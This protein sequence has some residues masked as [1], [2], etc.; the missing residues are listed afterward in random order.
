MPWRSAQTVL[1]VGKWGA[2]GAVRLWAVNT[3]QGLNVFEGHSNF[4]WSVAFS[5]DGQ[6]LA[7]GSADHSIR[8]WDVSNRQCFQTLQGHTNWVFVLGFSPDG[9]YLVSSGYDRRLVVWDA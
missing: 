7:S 6:T 3:G 2:G 1:Y 4:V 5:P 9:R 8:L